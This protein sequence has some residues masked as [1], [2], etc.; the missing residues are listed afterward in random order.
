MSLGPIELLVVKF[1]GN[2]FRGEISPALKE[3]VEGRIIRIV[4]I[5]FLHKGGDGRLRA[6]PG[7][8]TVKVPP[9]Y[10]ICE[11]CHGEVHPPG[12][13]GVR[14]SAPGLPQ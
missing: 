8:G 12:A 14:A 11:M 13:G 7:I 5:L 1:P 9:G 4:D 10:S 3:L 2:Q 6:C